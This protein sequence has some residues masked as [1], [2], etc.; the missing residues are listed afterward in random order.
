M[1][2]VI[3][4]QSEIGNNASS[5]PSSDWCPATIKEV[6]A[7]LAT[8][9]MWA[10]SREV[11]CRKL[12]RSVGARWL[13]IFIDDRHWA[14]SR[15]LGG[16]ARG[17]GG[18]IRATPDPLGHTERGC[19]KAFVPSPDELATSPSLVLQTKHV[20]F[21]LPYGDEFIFLPCTT[22]RTP[23]LYTPALGR[24]TNHSGHPVQSWLNLSVGY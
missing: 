24:R 17:L 23:L 1:I 2:V 13:S 6:S 20:A 7:D 21:T 4:K 18:G 5:S 10:S 15:T 3:I 9:G 8:V 16:F 12:D 14:I 22:N 19:V 11:A